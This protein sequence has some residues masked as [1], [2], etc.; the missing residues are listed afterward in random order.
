MAIDLDLFRVSMQRLAAAVTVVATGVAGSRAG[1][2]ASAVT[3]LT[4]EPP[5]LLVCVNRDAGSH[6][7]LVEEGRFSVSVLARG[8]GAVAEAFAGWTGL[9]GEDR[10]TVGEWSEGSIGVPMLAGALVGFECVLDALYPRST[11][12]IIVGHIEHAHVSDGV[13]EPLLYLDRR[14][15]GF[16]E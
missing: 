1:L 7:S 11:H 5:T 10:F 3:S 2:T 15:G 8:Q 16:A 14:F 9:E 13:I 12:D 6:V 4:A